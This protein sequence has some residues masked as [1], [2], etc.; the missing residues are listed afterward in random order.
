MLMLESNPILSIKIKNSIFV[1]CKSDSFSST[2]FHF[3]GSDRF[4]A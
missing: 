4:S 1:T 3:L 2:Q